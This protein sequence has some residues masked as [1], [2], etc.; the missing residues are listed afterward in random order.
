MPKLALTSVTVDLQ[1]P[2]IGGVSGTW[3]P[4]TK[5]RS[6]AWELYVELVTR[7][8]T[9]ELRSGECILREALTSLHSLFQTTRQ[10]LKNY[11]PEIAQPKGNGKFSFGYLAVAI[12]NT[13]L[14]PVLSKWHPLL[15]DYESRRDTTLSCYEHERQ[16]EHYDELLADIRGAQHT[17]INFANTLAEVAKVPS[18]IIMLEQ[19]I[20]GGPECTPTSSQ[21]ALLK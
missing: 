15:S 20:N 9:V 14:R 19:G 16:W 4:D 11:G 6:A 13:V 17:L 1:L 21:S 10:I 18:L 5:E 2:Y 12:L 7:S 3:E 8:A